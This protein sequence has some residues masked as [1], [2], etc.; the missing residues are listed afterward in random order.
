[1]KVKI[2][3]AKA[4]DVGVISEIEK[5]CF[6]VPWS[7][8]MLRSDIVDSVVADYFTAKDE[9]G[10]MLGFSG[11]YDVAEE[12]HITNIAVL[13]LY[14]GRGIAGQLVAAMIKNA[15]M[16]GCQAVT[17]EVRIGNEPAI[18]LYRRHGF[19]TEGIRKHYY[20]DNGEDALIMWLNFGGGR[21]F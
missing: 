5:I 17:L 11:M 2:S 19:V 7:Y 16:H 13:P 21:K 9:Q 1:M 20:S 18:R 15:V 3:K 14:R 8:E 12:A 6:T 10:K 4:S